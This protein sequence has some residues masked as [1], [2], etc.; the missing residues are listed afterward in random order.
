VG[1]PSLLLTKLIS[2]A[3]LNYYLLQSVSKF[4]LR[5]VIQTRSS[6]K[7]IFLHFLGVSHF[8]LHCRLIGT[9]TASYFTLRRNPD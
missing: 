1:F 3:S 8:Q 4:L 5:T 7:F 6:F 9:Y 2:G